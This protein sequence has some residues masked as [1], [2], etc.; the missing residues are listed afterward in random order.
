ME[1]TSKELSTKRTHL[2]CSNE[3][4]VLVLVRHLEVDGALEVRRLPALR[5]GRKLA[6]T[7]KSDGSAV[8]E[9]PVAH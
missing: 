3:E 6:A 2:V 7:S 9:G 4:L 5:G 1:R 8:G